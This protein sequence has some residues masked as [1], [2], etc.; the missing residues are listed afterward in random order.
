[1]NQYLF[2]DSIFN[3]YDLSNNIIV[4]ATTFLILHAIMKINDA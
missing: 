3:K 2:A 1:M 4:Y